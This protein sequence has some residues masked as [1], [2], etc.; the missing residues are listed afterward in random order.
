MTSSA[1][2]PARLVLVADRSPTFRQVAGRVLGHEGEWQC[3]TASTIREARDKIVQLRP[4]VLVVES[5]MAGNENGE[6]VERLLQY[7]PIPV[8]VL[9]RTRPA[10][11][12]YAA[13]V[14]RAGSDEHAAESLARALHAW[15]G[16][17]AGRPSLK[18]SYKMI[19][20]GASTG[21]TEAVECVLQMLPEDSPGIVIAQHIPRQFSATFAARLNRVTGLEVREAENGDVISDG[22][23]L[24][25]PGDQHLRVALAGDHWEVRLDIGPKVWHQRPAV[26]ILFSTVA[27][28]AGRY[29]VGV[30]LTGMGQ[31]GAAGLLEMRQAGCWTIAQ[32]EASCVIFGMPRA[33]IETGAVCEVAPLER[34]AAAIGTQVR[35]GESRLARR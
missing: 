1:R 10:S 35:S 13:V 7:Y 28:H 9:A 21:G 19:A 33:A 25:A 12:P 15:G 24:V 2:R 20:I 17:A 3:V 18:A 11:L 32:D 5:E 22:L 26:D 34:V 30:L 16:S 6:F 29:A 14:M 8:M 31:D 23:A 27:K 4:L